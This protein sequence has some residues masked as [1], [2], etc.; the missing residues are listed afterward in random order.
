MSIGKVQVKLSI[1]A[2]EIITCKWKQKDSTNRLLELRREFNTVSGYKIK[3]QKSIV[4]A[5]TNNFKT[6]NELV[7]SILFKIAAYK[8]NTLG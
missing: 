8:L 5:Y 7:I 1:L 2:C 6:W 4:F 3:V